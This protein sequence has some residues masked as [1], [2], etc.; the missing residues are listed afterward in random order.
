M[1]KI[2]GICGVARAGKDTLCEILQDIFP[3]KNMTRLAFADALKTECECFLKRN[4]GISAFTTDE[5]EKELIRPFLV[6]YG[7][8]LRRR[9]DP[10]CW[11]KVLSKIINAHGETSNFIITDARYVNELEWIKESKG[12]IIHVSREGVN[13]ANSEEESND[14]ILKDLSDYQLDLPTF[15]NNYFNKCKSTIKKQL[16]MPQIWS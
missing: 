15:T 13:P 1:S 11:I 16:P 4:L 2:I 14:P 7:T 12:V 10:N 9:L 3:E 5:R 6:T 8:H